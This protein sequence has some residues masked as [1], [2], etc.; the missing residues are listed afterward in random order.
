ML[1]GRDRETIK[2]LRKE[3]GEARRE[4]ERKDLEQHEFRDWKKGFGVVWGEH[5]VAHF[6]LTEPKIQSREHSD[7]FKIASIDALIAG[8]G[9]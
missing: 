2:K 6:D 3:L 8:T 7:V 1:F 4:L 5:S 9:R